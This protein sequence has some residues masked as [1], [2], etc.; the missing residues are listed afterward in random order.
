MRSSV[1]INQ[2]PTRGC[3]WCHPGG[4]FTQL[5]THTAFVVQPKHAL[6]FHLAVMMATQP[7]LSKW[8]PSTCC[9]PFFFFFVGS[10]QTLP[11]SSVP[12][13][14]WRILE[15]ATNFLLLLFIYYCQDI[16][17]WHTQVHTKTWRNILFDIKYCRYIWPALEYYVLLHPTVN[18][19]TFKFIRLNKS[20]FKDA[21]FFFISLYF[22]ADAIKLWEKILQRN[23][24]F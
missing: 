1:E 2:N 12:V 4:H 20:D 18:S 23:G 22:A 13:S 8:C 10:N 15:T 24:L 14:H 7:L 17:Y 21:G 6:N 11:F 3:K 19:T 9:I 16:L 5:Y